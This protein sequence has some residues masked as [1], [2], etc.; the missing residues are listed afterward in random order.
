MLV[1]DE[2]L[3]KKMNR[4]VLNENE[5]ITLSDLTRIMMFLHFLSM[6]CV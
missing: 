4:S 6:F 2:N 3:Y 5:K 1:S